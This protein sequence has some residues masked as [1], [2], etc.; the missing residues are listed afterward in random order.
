[1]HIHTTITPRA[2]GL[3]LIGLLLCASLACAKPLLSAEVARLLE[4]HGVDA[5]RERFAELWTNSAAD[6]EADVEGLADLGTRYLEAGNIEAGMAV[7]EMVSIVSLAGLETA[8]ESQAEMVAEMEAAAAELAADAGAEAAPGDEG[9]APAASDRGPARTDLARLTGIYASAEAP[10]RELFVTRTCDGFL[11]AGPLWAD[12]APWDLRSQGGE[13]FSFRQG[14]LQFQLE[15]ATGNDGAARE[16][17]HTIRGLASPM[18]RR[19][20]L[21]DD[22]RRCQPDTAAVNSVPGP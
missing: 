15:F 2:M 3:A 8:L 18:Q 13:T 16:L 21:P 5:A 9:P 12:T 10:N 6:Y 20:P 11:V 17:S 14:E 1:M 7:M 19:R 4:S 22:W